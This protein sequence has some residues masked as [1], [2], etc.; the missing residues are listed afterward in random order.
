MGSIIG[1]DGWLRKSLPAECAGHADVAGHVRAP[2]F[3]LCSRSCSI[4][5]HPEGDHHGLVSFVNSVL[6]QPP[7]V[8]GSARRIGRI[9]QVFGQRAKYQGSEGLVTEVLST[10]LGVSEARDHLLRCHTSP[11]P[12]Y[13]SSA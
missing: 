3:S 7:V 11:N 8:R 12:R 10:R 4:G 1:I 13:L 6:D 5:L 9:K 2:G